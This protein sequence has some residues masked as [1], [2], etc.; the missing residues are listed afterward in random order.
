M[1]K[2]Q[3]NIST[4]KFRECAR[5][6]VLKL[7]MRAN[8]S[9]VQLCL[10]KKRTENFR[11]KLFRHRIVLKFCWVL[12]VS[13]SPCTYRNH[14]PLFLPFLLYIFFW[15]PY[16]IG[17]FGKQP[18]LVGQSVN[19]RRVKNHFLLRGKKPHYQHGSY[20]EKYEKIRDRATSHCVNLWVRREW[21]GSVEAINY[22]QHCT[23]SASKELDPAQCFHHFTL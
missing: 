5:K 9:D 11:S 16:I 14:S 10:S 23:C 19:R 1:L 13:W 2:I 3:S 12:A 6:Y 18:V 8:I 17:H 20:F 22:I 4:I 15:Y 21:L 7:Q